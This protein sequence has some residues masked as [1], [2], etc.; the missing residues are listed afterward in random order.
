MFPLMSEEEL[1]GLAEDI[2][3]RG[4]LL[5]PIVLYQGAVLD[6]RN[7]LEACRRAEVSPRYVEWSGPGSPLEWVVGKNLRRRH[8]SPSQRAVM[9]LQLLPLLEKEAAERKRRGAVSPVGSIAQ[10]CA[11]LPERGSDSRGNASLH[12]ARMVGAGER[13][14]QAARRVQRNW[15][16]LLPHVTAGKL[17][18]IH[19]E[20]GAKLPVT[21]RASLLEDLVKA[22]PGKAV[23]F[24]RMVHEFI[25]QL[26]NR[27]A[28]LTF[29]PGEWL[30]GFR[31]SEVLITRTFEVKLTMEEIAA[32][33]EGQEVPVKL[34]ARWCLLRLED[35]AEPPEEDD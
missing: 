31:D 28:G 3:E 12:A 4:E 27:R 29:R 21:W 8:F 33:D 25:T 17:H 34:G 9:A 2:R 6:G 35:D 5:E 20:Q 15:P 22:P 7:R 26:D 30:A 13:Y 19:A 14:V 23:N 18:L 10:N 16:E 32:L 1:E 11:M 24:P